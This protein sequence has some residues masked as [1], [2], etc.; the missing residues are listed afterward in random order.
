MRLGSYECDHD[1]CGQHIDGSSE[2]LS[3]CH[4]ESCENYVCQ[5]CCEMSTNDVVD[6][7]ARCPVCE[8]SG[9]LRRVEQ[10]TERGPDPTAGSPDVTSRLHRETQPDDE[11]A[12]DR[13]RFLTLS[14]AAC[15][16]PILAGC[17]EQVA[18]GGERP[19]TPGETTGDDTPTA[20]QSPTDTPTETPKEETV[21]FEDDFSDGNFQAPLWSAD[22]NVAIESVDHPG[23]GNNAMAL[24]GE[25]SGN[26]TASPEDE[27]EIRVTNRFEIEGMFRA[28]Q[29]EVRSEP[30]EYK[31]YVG[32]SERGVGITVEISGPTAEREQLNV[33][34]DSFFNSTGTYNYLVDSTSSDISIAWNRDT[35]YRYRLWHRGDG[36]FPMKVWP[37]TE[38]EP[39]TPGMVGIGTPPADSN[40][41]ESGFT[42]QKGYSGPNGV[43]TTMYHAFVRFKTDR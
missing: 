3:V 20:T 37:A 9:G 6:C 8:N 31:I 14:G 36:E 33:Y 22:E 21:V 25:G 27:S 19:D 15:G 38:P 4:C 30:F 24:V 17:L 18:D 35:W 28:T 7:D 10:P 1:E 16:A 41:D 43:Q 39:D 23:S 5:A 32:G 42:L 40:Y 12:V 26:V 11:P 29:T 13:R 2:V 34:F